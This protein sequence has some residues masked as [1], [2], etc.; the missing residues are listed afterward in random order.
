MR[1]S[2]I[3]SPDRKD[4]IILVEKDGWKLHLTLKTA[5]RLLDEH[6]LAFASD[7]YMELQ[8]A[9]IDAERAVLA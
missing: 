9:V 1:A 7:T 6:R 5:R 2:A 8:D 4:C 3:I